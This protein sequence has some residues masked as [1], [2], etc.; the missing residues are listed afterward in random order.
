MV[1]SVF[2]DVMGAIA[3]QNAYAPVQYR[4]YGGPSYYGGPPMRYYPAPQQNTYDNWRRRNMIPQYGAPSPYLDDEYE[5]DVVAVPPPV[6]QQAPPAPPVSPKGLL[7]SMAVDWSNCLDRSLLEDT[8]NNPDAV[9]ARCAQYTPSG[10]AA[11]ERQGY[12]RAQANDYIAGLVM[13]ARQVAV[14]R[15]EK[16]QQQ[17]RR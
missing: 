5:S 16:R 13:K 17:A 2:M 6:V 15:L 10:V 3:Q 8:T 7:G 12:T 14:E 4:P 11:L 1:L 9:L